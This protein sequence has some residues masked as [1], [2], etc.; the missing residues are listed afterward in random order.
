MDVGTAVRPDRLA[1]LRAMGIDPTAPLGGDPIEPGPGDVRILAIDG[2]GSVGYHAGRGCPRQIGGAHADHPPARG[3]HRIP[4]RPP[5]I[6]RLGADHAAKL[7]NDAIG[8]GCLDTAG[9]RH[10]RKAAL[11]H[12]DGIAGIGRRDAVLDA[13][14]LETAARG[15]KSAQD[16][17]VKH[18]ARLE[19]AYLF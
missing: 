16:R 12:R 10:D 7:G 18:D 6:G 11:G 1:A 2:A 9:G 3:A 15:T 17:V 13:P 8:A 5:E 4:A 19:Q 14:L